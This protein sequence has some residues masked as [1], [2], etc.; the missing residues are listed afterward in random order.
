VNGAE[1]DIQFLKGKNKKKR[2]GG[3]PDMTMDT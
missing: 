2:G 1:V 3:G